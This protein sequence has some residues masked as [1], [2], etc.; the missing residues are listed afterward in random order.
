MAKAFTM[1]S[2]ERLRPSAVRLAAEF[3]KAMTDTGPPADLVHGFA[4]PMPFAVICELLGVPYEDRGEFAQW[5]SDATSAK[6]SEEQR[7]GTAQ[8]GRLLWPGQTSKFW[9]PGLMGAA[10]RTCSLADRRGTSPAWPSGRRTI[11][12]S[13]RLQADPASRDAAVFQAEVA[14]VYAR[15]GDVEQACHLQAALSPAAAVQASPQWF[16]GALD[17]DGYRG[18]SAEGDLEYVGLGRV[19]IEGTRKRSPAKR[20]HSLLYTGLLSP[21]SCAEV[22]V[23]VKPT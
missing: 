22:G 23:Q 10:S 20:W 21:G 11:T 14:T 15:Q 13:I 18:P 6:A 7:R 8:A 17:V 2:A 1:R 12:N 5:V 3:I 16:V 19:L 9:V 4:I